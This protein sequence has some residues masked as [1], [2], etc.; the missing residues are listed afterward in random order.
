[1]QHEQLEPKNERD[2]H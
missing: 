2:Q 1:M